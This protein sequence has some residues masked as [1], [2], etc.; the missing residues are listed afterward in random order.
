ML[1]EPAILNMMSGSGALLMSRDVLWMSRDVLLMLVYGVKST[2]RK[3]LEVA[4]A[5]ARSTDLGAGPEEVP[6]STMNTGE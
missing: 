1:V 3:R 4:W 2:F 5:F 6:S